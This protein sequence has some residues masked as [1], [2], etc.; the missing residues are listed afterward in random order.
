MPF[1]ISAPCALQAADAE[2]VAALIR[3]AFA[4][5]PAPVDP[6]PSALLETADSVAAGLAAGGGSLVRAG[7]VIV[8]AVLWD[9]RN[10]GLYLGR[11]SVHPQWRGRGIAR[12]LV[13]TA[14]Q[15]ARDAGLPRLHLS[16][17]L[18]MTGNRALFAACGFVEL[19]LHAHPGYAAP[20]YVS[21]EKRLL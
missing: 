11:L 2:A 1:D 17:R 6:P 3:L 18:A 21:L 13:A 14:E 19:S 4:T 9:R 5:L 7:D 10:G 12:R 16:T 8:G 15:A 20:T